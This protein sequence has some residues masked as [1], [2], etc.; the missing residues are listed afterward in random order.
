[1]PC[2]P[3]AAPSEGIP[4]RFDPFGERAITR[5]TGDRWMFAANRTS[6]ALFLPLALSVACASKADT[7]PPDRAEDDARVDR[8]VA[9]GR[10]WGTIKCFHPYLAYRDVDWDRALIET[11]PQVEAAESAADLG[12][13][14]DHLLSFL[15]DP[16]AQTYVVGGE[17]ESTPEPGAV[18]KDVGE[19]EPIFV[20]RL[21]GH[22]LRVVANYWAEI[23][24]DA[25]GGPSFAPAF[26]ECRDAQGIIL[27]LR[28]RSEADWRA[29]RTF[30]SKLVE[31]LP[32]LLSEPVFLSSRRSRVHSGYPPQRG[33]SSGGYFSA[34]L[35]E[36][37]EVLRPLEGR[38]SDGVPW[39]VLVNRRTIGL[40]DLLGGLQSARLATVVQEGDEA[41]AE[42]LLPH[43]VELTDSVFVAVRTHELRNADGTVGSRRRS[44]CCDPGTLLKRGPGLLPRRGSSARILTPT[45]IRFPGS[46]GCSDSSASGT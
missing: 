19:E 43:W 4:P 2:Y 18:Q 26:G 33:A 15:D 8:L 22:V 38:H 1:M 14:M 24:A 39:I 41:P 37:H 35:V 25:R 30:R 13:A 46:I 29:R 10:V 32:E 40:D 16:S 11:I 34:L 20:E 12:K 31:D 6:K 7:Q 3:T 27:D 17:T 5:E 28:D 44:S 42:N 21:D 9:L 36:E 23:G 45:W